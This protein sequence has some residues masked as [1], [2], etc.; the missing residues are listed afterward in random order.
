VGERGASLARHPLAP[1]DEAGAE[2][3]RRDPGLE[4]GEVSW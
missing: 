4:P 2:P 3:A 1:R